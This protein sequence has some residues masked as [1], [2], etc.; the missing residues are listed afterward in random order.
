[1]CV[2]VCL[3]VCV[4]VCACVHASVNLYDGVALRV[5][6]GGFHWTIVRAAEIQV[7]WSV[8]GSITVSIQDYSALL[9][10]NRI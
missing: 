3:C 8:Q 5:C 10:T 4:C 6:V 9:T 2:F 7:Y 1:V